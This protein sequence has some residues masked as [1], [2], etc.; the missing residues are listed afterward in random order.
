MDDGEMMPASLTIEPLQN[1]KTPTTTTYK[2]FL[3]LI[4]LWEEQGKPMD[5]KVLF[6]SRDVA[7]ILN[8]KWSGTVSTQLER[9]LAVLDSAKF[10]WEWSFI[11]EENEKKAL[12]QRMNILTNSTYVKGR[13]RRKKEKFTSL[14]TVTFHEYIVQ[15]LLAGI[16]KPINFHTIL[17]IKNEGA[18]AL[19]TH[20]DIILS[21]KT[22]WER[23]AVNLIKDLHLTGERYNSKRTR[24]AKL[25]EWIRALHGKSLSH[26]KLALRIE[27]TKSGDDWK[28]IVRRTPK[29]VKNRLPRSPENTPELRQELLELIDGVIGGLDTHKRLY[30]LFVASYSHRIIRQAV[31]EY[32]V[33]VQNPKN[34]GAAFTVILHRIAHMHGKEWIKDCGKSCK[35]RPENL[36]L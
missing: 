21:D 25:E 3:A 23:T 28:L 31:S 6:S 18:A 24:K 30:G 1:H 34:P 4:Q 15:N 19:Y 14:H 12:V 9:E 13:L 7:N 5:G 17:S 10:T 8:L 22:L 32:K 26:G 35:Y 27:E 29:R 2:Y 11:D 20:L 36:L 16:T 33:D